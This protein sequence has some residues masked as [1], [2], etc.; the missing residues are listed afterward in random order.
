MD[1]EAENK[2]LLA[3]YQE[4]NDN[5][6]LEQLYFNNRGL[7]YKVCCKYNYDIDDLMQECYFALLKAVN[8]YQEDKGAFNMYLAKAAHFHLFKYL[9]DIAPVYIP[10]YMYT[11]IK[12]YL[13]LKAENKNTDDS[14]KYLLDLND[15]QLEDIKKAL[16]TRNII[17]LDDPLDDEGET[18]R[19]DLVKDSSVN[20]EETALDKIYVEELAA[21]I[22]EELENLTEIEKSYLQLRF[23]ESKTYKEIEP[24]KSEQNTKAKIDRTLRKLKRSKKLQNFYDEVNFYAGSTLTAYKRNNQSIIERI[25][26]Y[27][28]ELEE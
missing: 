26:L 9:L 1:Y 27:K 28:M 3:L 7:L 10:G 16:S 18:T 13:S 14:I 6:Y 8:T 19:A 4:T 17:S 20:L 22:D 2:K 23:F 21:A 11:L 12:K 25:V 15:D 24:E 5:Y